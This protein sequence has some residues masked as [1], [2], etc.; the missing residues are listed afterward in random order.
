MR[1]LSRERFR[2]STGIMVLSI[3]AA[4]SISTVAFAVGIASS[5]ETEAE[6]VAEKVS[7]EGASE[8][9]NRTIEKI[10]DIS[11][12]NM[13]EID[14]EKAVELTTESEE[15]NDLEQDASGKNNV[16]VAQ[17]PSYTEAEDVSY[18]D[19]YVDDTS[20]VAEYVEEAPVYVE[21]TNIY[22]YCPTNISGNVLYCS[23]EAAPGE[24]K[25]GI[26][27]GGVRVL[28]T[29]PGAWDS[30][31]VCDPS[32]V[33]GSFNFNGTSYTYL[34][35][36][37]GCATYDCTANE[38]GFAV[39][40]DLWNWTKVGR[41]VEA[42]RDGA[43]GVGQPSL[44]NIGGGSDILLFYT[45][46]TSSLTTTYVKSL[47]CGDLNNIVDNGTKRIT[48]SYD[49]I[50]NADFAYSDGKIYMTCDTHPFNAG[51][52]GF[53]SDIQSVYSASWDTGF[54]SLDS[55]SWSVEAQISSSQ[56]GYAKNHNG[57]F[58]RDNYGNLVGRQ[59]MV[60][61]ASEVGD[62]LANLFTYRF[63]TVSF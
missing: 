20:D 38:I 1:K 39:S 13:A 59:L 52:L 32:V 5:K 46:G 28:A 10:I 19:S 58:V 3:I 44:L 25:D 24:V 22:K 40:N 18:V 15:Q 49:Y 35:A 2:R 37:L 29:T 4:F 62:Y 51:A 11:T 23:N 14:T 53:I 8:E 41:V 7:T 21:P 50:S 43:W 54:D 27:I 16:N 30:V 57:C 31:Q 9:T 61:T 33:A 12:E 45:S 48:C 6:D 42:V 60:S 63:M 26:C 34:M 47:S 17:N 56:T 36:Y 55:L